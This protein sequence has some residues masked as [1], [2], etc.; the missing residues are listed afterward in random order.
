M[1]PI[2]P[3]ARSSFQGFLLATPSSVVSTLVSLP[4]SAPTASQAAANMARTTALASSLAL[5]S[6]WLSVSSRP[7]VAATATPGSLLIRGAVPPAALAAS[8]RAARAIHT[9]KANPA[10]V[11]PICGTGPPPKP[12]KPVG[13]GEGAGEGEREG[14]KGRNARQEEDDYDPAEAARRERLA[15]RRRL[16]ELLK[17]AGDPKAALK[18]DRNK[19]GMARRFW[20]T[21]DV[22]EV[23]GSL[24]IHLDSRPLRHPTTKAIVRLPVTKPNLAHAIA[25]EWDALTSAQQ[26]T[27]QHRIPLTSLTCRALDIAADDAAAAPA[28]AAAAAT[29]TS[30]S[31]PPY[32]ATPLR[33]TIAALL[34]RYL[35][36][37]SLLIFSPPRSPIDPSLPSLHETQRA[38]YA[39]A[40]G[41]LTAP[42]EQGGLWPGLDVRPVDDGS[43]IM[44]RPHPPETREAVRRWIAHAL[45]PFEL[46]GLERATLAGKS[47]LAAAR[48]VAEWSEQGAGRSP[49]WSSSE[50]EAQ[51]FGVEEAARAVSLEVD[52]QTKQWG[53]VEDTHDVE[54]EDVRRQFGSVVL[55]VSGTGAAAEAA[56]AGKSNI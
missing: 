28:P 2:P 20:K 41:A 22:K 46:A 6:R 43:S 21:V 47:L 40:V 24:Q 55:L 1:Y 33:T 17:Q 7:S 34:L 27:K 11:V 12:P 50:A 13:E 25:V 35:D 14:E 3:R 44:P 31:R 19:G 15:R 32:P 5:S 30:P 42:R 8:V 18:D 48:L 29:P 4:T 51:R 26:A 36:T 52:Y 37:D 53:E 23:D 10:R 39:A 16:A 45:S 9:N 38:A 49:S 54:R 56:E